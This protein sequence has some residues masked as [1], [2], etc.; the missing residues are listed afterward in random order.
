[1]ADRLF[2][3][4]K[5]FNDLNA[6]D[7]LPDLAAEFGTG[8]EEKTFS[9]IASKDMDGEPLN[10]Q[11]SAPVFAY[12]ADLV[13]EH[14]EA[15]KFLS[16][17]SEELNSFI[18]SITPADVDR[19]KAEGCTFEQ[20]D[21]ADFIGNAIEK[22][23][24]LEAFRVLHLKDAILLYEHRQQKKKSSNL[25]IARNSGALEASENLNPML[26]T[27]KKFRNAFST[28]PNKHAYVG[29]FDAAFL[30]TLIFSE[31]EFDEI[32][33]RVSKPDIE[34]SR[35]TDYKQLEKKYDENLLMQ[36]AAAAYNSMVR[37]DSMS[38]TVYLPKFLAG[39]GIESNKGSNE[40]LL[41]KLR[42]LE[43]VIGIMNNS[44]SFSRAFVIL[45][46]DK[47]TQQATFSMPYL[48][49]LLSAI[50]QDTKRV[51]KVKGGTVEYNNPA[52]SW[53]IRPTIAKVRN[54]PAVA[55]VRRLVAGLQERGAKPDIE[56]H[57]GEGYNFSISDAALITYRI[58]YST[59]IEDIPLLNDKLESASNNNKNTLLKRAF[60]PVAELLE[61][62]TDVYRYYKDLK[63]E[64]YPPTCRTLKQKITITHRGKD[65]S[66]SEEN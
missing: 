23:T 31:G 28:K 16:T 15:I 46:V 38:V 2:E 63:V 30:S 22:G 14:G 61:K 25:T 36:C 17:D 39:M 21:I 54:K 44:T 48:N 24:L 33:N 20:N 41:E 5:N 6:L 35:I 9:V 56:L 34:R 7:A 51:K 18:Q 32:R 8:S 64:I 62:E 12:V 55:I 57:K 11:F 4:L 10:V 58:S 45:D 49:R 13:K 29:V 37:H 40:T 26:I 52:F 3:L 42:E 66:Y 43:N 65:E 19:I 27:T 47:K 50:E 59:I 53:L 1:M 60:S